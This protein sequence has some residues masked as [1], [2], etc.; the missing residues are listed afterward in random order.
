MKG[1]HPRPE[2]RGQP[3]SAE[4]HTMPRQLSALGEVLWHRYLLMARSLWGQGRNSAH[5]SRG[6]PNEGNG[7]NYL[8]QRISL[9]QQR[10]AKTGQ[11]KRKSEAATTYWKT[12]ILSETGWVNCCGSLQSCL[13][14]PVVIRITPHSRSIPCNRNFWT[15]YYLFHAN[16]RYS[17]PWG[18]EILPAARW[19]WLPKSSSSCLQ[20]TK[21]F[22][23]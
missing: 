14:S 6:V 10:K 22:K 17:G 3:F 1:S 12:S 5:G 13:I 23:S 2:A 9:F 11:Q 16:R 20:T 7:S 15:S 4:W 21:G 8:K 19:S 18:R